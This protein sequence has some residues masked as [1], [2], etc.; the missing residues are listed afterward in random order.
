MDQ[1]FATRLQVFVFRTFTVISLVI[2]TVLSIGSS[3]YDLHS[4]HSK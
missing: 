3:L 4:G 1:I 2:M